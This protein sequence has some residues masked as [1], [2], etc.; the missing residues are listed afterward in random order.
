MTTTT[1]PITPRPGVMSIAPY[2]VGG[3]HLAGGAPKF[4]L[5][6]NENAWGPSPKAV[7]AYSGAASRLADYPGADSGDLRRAIAGVYDVDPD[8]VICGNGSD[9]LLQL[10]GYGYLREG[11]E[12]VY[13]RHG[14]LLYPSYALMNGATPIAAAESDLTSDVDALLGACTDKTRLVYIANPNNPTGT[15]LNAQEV[16]RLAD[17]IPEQALLVLDGAYAEFV[18]GEDYDGGISLVTRRRNVVMSRTFS[19]IYGLA[20]LRVGWIYAPAHVAEVINRIRGP[21]NVNAAAQAAA[22]AAV[23]DIQYTAWVKAET[24]RLRADLTAALADLDIPC[25]P[26]EGNF[27]LARFGADPETGAAAAD[28]FL[29]S[30]GII[31]R[32]MDGYGL[33]EYLRISIGT[34]AGCRAVADAI[35][36]FRA[37]I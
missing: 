20:S 19:K 35:A 5:S 21:Y 34:E 30:R 10:L 32:R 26:S 6:A 18:E 12:V 1:S 25:T 24:I 14:F 7:A 3:S 13:S 31:V 17:G 22:V 36:A 27:V 8:L 9:E 33:G 15:R 11:D 28:S 29:K 37:G 2:V 16:A 4:K 23:R